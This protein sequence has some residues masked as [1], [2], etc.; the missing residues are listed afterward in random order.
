MSMEHGTHSR[1]EDE[2]LDHELYMKDYHYSS[3][4]EEEKKKKRKKLKEHKAHHA[5]SE[6]ESKKEK[7]KRAEWKMTE[8]KFVRKMFGFGVRLGLTFPELVERMMRRK[9]DTTGEKK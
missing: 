2:A 9:K 8:K 6:K 7:A 4:S 3:L 5:E 1:E